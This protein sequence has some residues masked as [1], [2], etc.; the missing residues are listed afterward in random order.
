MIDR[1]KSWVVYD[2]LPFLLSRVK[3]S[4]KD[5][6]EDRLY[7]VHTDV[8]S[9][10]GWLLLFTARRVFAT[11]SNISFRSC[12]FIYKGNNFLPILI[13]ILFH[14]Q[15]GTSRPKSSY[16]QRFPCPAQLLFLN[17]FLMVFIGGSRV[18]ALIGDKFL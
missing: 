10:I 3:C 2:R 15:E 4:K 1:S 13:K 6:L 5:L 11:V 16:G 9:M 14:V 8:S 12:W 7:M 17:E 18:A